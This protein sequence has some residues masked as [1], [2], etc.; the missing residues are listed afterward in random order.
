MLLSFSADSKVKSWAIV[1]M[2]S[3]YDAAIALITLG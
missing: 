3:N 1:A 2:T